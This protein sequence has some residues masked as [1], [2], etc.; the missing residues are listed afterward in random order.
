MSK[1]KPN[2]YWLNK[3][4][5]WNVLHGGGSRTVFNQ[6]GLCK[7]CPHSNKIQSCKLVKPSRDTTMPVIIK[8]RLM[9]SSDLKAINFCHNQF[10]TIDWICIEFIKHV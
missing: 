9:V 1:N 5:L 10:Y 3:F 2:E 8:N 6:Q 4:K 7:Y